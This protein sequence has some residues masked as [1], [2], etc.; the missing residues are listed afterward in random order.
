MSA[1]AKK[2]PACTPQSWEEAD[3]L[4]AEY[5]ELDGTATKLQARCDSAV[6]RVKASF[7]TKLAPTQARMAE[8]FDAV[9][10]Y[11]EANRKTLTDDGKTKTVT[12]TAGSF[13]WRLCPPSVAVKRGLTAPDLVT[14]VKALATRYIGDGKRKIARAVLCFVRLKEEPDKE[15]ML[16]NPDLAA[17]IEGI[18]IV[19]DKEEF[20]LS[21]DIAELPEPKG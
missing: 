21:T 6:A 16:K 14:S 5:G 4:I 7:Q 15:A 13:G 3:K 10:W 1:K 17:E 19:T 2:A 20:F 11:A 12:M 9:A 18:R 8:I